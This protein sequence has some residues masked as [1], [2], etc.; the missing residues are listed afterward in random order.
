MQVVIEMTA[1]RSRR[2]IFKP[3]ESKPLRSRWNH[4]AASRQGSASA[5]LTELMAVAPDIPGMA[6]ALDVKNRIGKVFDPLRETE[7]GRAIWSRMKPVLD[8]NP[9]LCGPDTQPQ[10]TSMRENMD[11]D[12]MKTWLWEMRKLVD[13]GVATVVSGQMPEKE[14]IRK[15]PGKRQAVFADPL[16]HHISNESK[17]ADSVP[18]GRAGAGATA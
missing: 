8:A 11:E 7:D 14:Q 18:A 3:N 2:V 10:K 12:A 13:S 5:S 16:V 4:A 9:D 15:L 17:Y 6:I 1:P